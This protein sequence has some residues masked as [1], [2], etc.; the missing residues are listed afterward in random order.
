MA[1]LRTRVAVHNYQ[2]VSPPVAE[3]LSVSIKDVYETNVAKAEFR[4]ACNPGNVDRLLN[5]LSCKLSVAL[6]RPRQ[7]DQKRRQ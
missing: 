4:E 1:L 5:F 3:Q 7:R 6:R 2:Q